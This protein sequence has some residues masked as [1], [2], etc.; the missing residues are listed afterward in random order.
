MA[1]KRVIH[2]EDNNKYNG[3][4]CEPMVMTYGMSDALLSSGLL[5][6]I[7]ALTTQDK[8]CLLGY[9]TQDVANDDDEDDGV[10]WDK[11][12][13]DLPPYTLDELYARIDESHQQYL[14]GEYMTEAEV[15]EELKKEVVIEDIWDMH[16]APQNL[17]KRMTP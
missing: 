3:E 11:M 14:R 15:R 6:Q 9:I 2:M 13:S 1:Q 5:T 4:V 12:D 17:I 16:R 8:K 10:D 7:H